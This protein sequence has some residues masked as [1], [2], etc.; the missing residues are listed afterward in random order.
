MPAYIVIRVAVKN[1]EAYREY[2]LH[3]PRIVAQYGGRFLVRGGES[4]TL[5]GPPSG[6]RIV[7]LEF[8][9]LE[10]A[11]A[12]YHSP[13]YTKARALREGGGDASFIAIDGYP[14]A[15]WQDVLA[16]S[17]QLSFD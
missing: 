3:S 6:D 11:Q 8:P 15:A 7:V 10:Q 13:E 12:F 14:D 17:N 1:P 4:V 9:S 5:E 2:T 16:A